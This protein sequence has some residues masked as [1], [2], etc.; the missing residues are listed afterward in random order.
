MYF[1]SLGGWSFPLGLGR[2]LSEALTCSKLSLTL[3]FTRGELGHDCCEKLVTC[4]LVL[5][6]TIE[7]ELLLSKGDLTLR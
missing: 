6:F 4:D 2:K 3:G 1:L 5:A 7:G